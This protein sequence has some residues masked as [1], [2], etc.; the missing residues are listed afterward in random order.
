[1]KRVPGKLTQASDATRR[2][3]YANITGRSLEIFK[4]GAEDDHLISDNKH[5]A[6]KGDGKH[7]CEL[8]ACHYYW[9]P[10]KRTEPSWERP[11]GLLVEFTGNGTSTGAEY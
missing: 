3:T 5:N 1:M 11:E 9:G 10:K 8:S 4:S 2:E 6:T 7:P